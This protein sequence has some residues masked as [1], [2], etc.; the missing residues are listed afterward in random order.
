MENFTH[1]TTRFPIK[2]HTTSPILFLMS[3][4]LKKRNHHKTTNK[5]TCHHSRLEN[6]HSSQAPQRSSA[7]AACSSHHVP[8]ARWVKLCK[9]S[10]EVQERSP[11]LSHHIAMFFHINSYQNLALAP[12]NGLPSNIP[13]GTSNQN[14]KADCFPSAVQNV[15]CQRTKAFVT[16]W[17]IFLPIQNGWLA[18][19]KST[20]H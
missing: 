9:T 11:L 3:I 1:S 2:N 4:C 10:T 15:I 6:H 7:T 18:Y 20:K 19:F 5:Q 14:P 12:F 8:T 16:I 17:N 13:V